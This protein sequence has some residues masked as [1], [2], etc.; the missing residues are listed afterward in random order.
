MIVTDSMLK[1]IY[2]PGLWFLKSRHPSSDICDLVYD[3]AVKSGTRV[4]VKT[5]DNREMQGN[6][7]TKVMK[8]HLDKASD[9]NERD[10]LEQDMS[11]YHEHGFFSYSEDMN[12]YAENGYFWRDTVILMD[13]LHEI[14]NYSN[15]IIILED[16]NDLYYEDEKDLLKI[17]QS[18][19]V[20]A[21]RHKDTMIILVQEKNYGPAS[22]F[23]ETHLFN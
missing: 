7:I 11:E 22:D 12:E 4:L 1:K 19:H 8:D 5:Q 9:Q 15:D 6:I 18:N 14:G 17:L 20:D 10:W 23:I 13:D 21:V 3:L 2:M 16:I